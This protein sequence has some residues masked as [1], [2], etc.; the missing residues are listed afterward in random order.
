MLKE[1]SAVGICFPWVINPCACSYTYPRQYRNSITI[2]FRGC[3][4]GSVTSHEIHWLVT[5]TTSINFPL[6][7][8]G[9]LEMQVQYSTV[10]SVD[11]LNTCWEILI[12]FAVHSHSLKILFLL[13]IV[14]DVWERT[15]FLFPLYSLFIDSW[16]APAASW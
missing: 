14:A 13:G 16:L 9:Q 7:K 3:I 15:Y 11:L 10:S 8:I 12:F 1:V 2:Q 4:E 5:R 6:I